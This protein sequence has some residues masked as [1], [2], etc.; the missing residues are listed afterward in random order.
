VGGKVN[1]KNK[2]VTPWRCGDCRDI[3][4]GKREVSNNLG[5][6]AK[7]KEDCRLLKMCG[8]QNSD[9]EGL[10]NQEKTK[11]RNFTREERRVLTG[12]S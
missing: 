3:G 2:E 1:K 11:K 12:F 5:N 7:E 4:S 8:G 6:E 10:A 9:S